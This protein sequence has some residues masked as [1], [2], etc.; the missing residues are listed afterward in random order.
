MTIDWVYKDWEVDHLKRKNIIY[1]KDDDKINNDNFDVS[2][3]HSNDN[4]NVKIRN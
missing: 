4:K 2:F 1:D 3:D